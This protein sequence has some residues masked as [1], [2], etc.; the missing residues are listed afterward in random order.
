MSK[1]QKNRN[2]RS[3]GKWFENYKGII[4]KKKVQ[5]IA[6]CSCDLNCSKKISK[7]ERL[8]LFTQFYELADNEKKQLYIWGMVEKNTVNRRTS[9]SQKYTRDLNY[10]YILKFSN[11]SVEVCSTFFHSTFAISKSTL[12]RWLSKSTVSELPH[13]SKGK[14]SHNSKDY[15]D[16]LAFFN[17]LPC[18]DSHYCRRKYSVKKFLDPGITIAKLYRIYCAKRTEEKCK[19]TVLRSKFYDIFRNETNL[20]IKHPHKDT[21]SKCASMQVKIN[22]CNNERKRKLLIQK[23]QNHLKDV[24]F[25]RDEMKKDKII[26]NEKNV[27]ITF[28]LQKALPFPML[29]VGP[30]YY[31]RK[32]YVYNFGIHRYPENFNA[33]FFVWNE[34]QGGRGAQE[35]ATCVIDYLRRFAPHAEEITIYCD[36]CG[37]QNRNIKMCLMLLHYL[38]DPEISV[39]TIDIKF[40]ISG[41]SYL[42]NDAD[43]GIIEKEIQ[44]RE[45]VFVPDEYFDIIRSCQQRNSF[46]LHEREFKDFKS[47]KSLENVITKRTIDINGEK[48]NWNKIA[49]LQLKKSEPLKILFKENLEHTAFRVLNIEKKKANIDSLFDISLDDMYNSS[50]SINELKLKDIRTL[51]QYIPKDK[52]AFFETLHS[53]LALEESETDEVDTEESSNE[54]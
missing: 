21:C 42:P 34:S 26:A 39:R 13:K 48:V 44:K 38:S 35:L 12:Y 2:N 15:S 47:S 17:S 19:P 49:H 43:F 25:V 28:D 51:L 23:K 14:K 37:G 3:R 1:I 4:K 54:E 16:V 6:D 11:R 8:F 5:P 9:S 46:M 20:S 27:M 36:R 22:G 45:Q 32:L 18:Y 41:H 40:M 10:K 24:E 33:H 31:A 52:T 7:S 50:R 29:N 30:A 53:S